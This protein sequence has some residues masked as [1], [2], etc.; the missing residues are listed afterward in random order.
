VL[1]ARA[2]R[3]IFVAD[4]GC[5]FLGTLSFRRRDGG[6]YGKVYAVT[7]KS[8]HSRDRAE[9]E[10]RTIYKCRPI[11]SDIEVVHATRIP[12]ETLDL[13]LIVNNLFLS[14]N[15][16]GLIKE[17]MRLTKPGGRLLVVEWKKDQLLL[18]RRTSAHDAAR[19]R[20][21]FARP[22]V[23]CIDRFDAA[24]IITSAFP[25]NRDADA[26][27]RSVCI[28]RAHE[29]TLCQYVEFPETLITARFC[30]I[31]KHSFCAGSRL[32]HPWSFDPRDDRRN[33][34]L[35]VYPKG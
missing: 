30:L 2:S 34:R 10:D 21:L 23:H 9:D 8:C 3:I 31:V 32:H 29:L 33:R 22:D 12:D 18:G 27:G 14:T 25:K 11:W 28:S 7:F 6:A 35:R 26:Y 5:G 24:N 4:L 20:A 13:T 19:S 16:D 1:D 17:A 15:R